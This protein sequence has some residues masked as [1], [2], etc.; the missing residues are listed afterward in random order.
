MEEDGSTSL[1]IG[2]PFTDR[3][4]TVTAGMVIFSRYSFGSGPRS[5]VL[6]ST[7]VEQELYGSVFGG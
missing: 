5:V 3:D 1:L 4:G 7:A 6:A 2:A